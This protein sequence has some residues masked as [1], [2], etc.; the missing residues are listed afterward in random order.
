MCVQAGTRKAHSNVVI[1]LGQDKKHEYIYL[2]F[3]F[4]ADHNMEKEALDTRCLSGV[5]GILEK[6][7]N[8]TV[9]HIYYTHTA[10][11]GSAVKAQ[12][13]QYILRT[14]V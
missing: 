7:N 6:G 11:A 1:H 8:F 12:K 9:G 10:Q 5:M 3:P 14:R 13:T 2:P 4:C